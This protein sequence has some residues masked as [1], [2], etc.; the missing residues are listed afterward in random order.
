MLPPLKCRPKTGS[1]TPYISDLNNTAHLAPL[2]I[3]HSFCC[4]FMI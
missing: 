3:A 1:S 4:R 2:S